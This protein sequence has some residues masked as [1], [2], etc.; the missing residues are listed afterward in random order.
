MGIH[1][2]V[3]ESGT[4]L[5]VGV[6]GWWTD[7]M[8][9]RLRVHVEATSAEAQRVLAYFALGLLDA[10]AAG[11]LTRADACATFF[12]PVFLELAES[13]LLEP[14]LMQALHA[15]SELEDL[16]RLAPQ[17]LEPTIQTIRGKL[18]AALAHLS[19]DP[20]AVNGKRLVKVESE[21]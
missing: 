2:F 5:D 14:G 6:K 12:I 11:V 16:E 13:D 17:A 8:Q 20:L 3:H 4:M 7:P 19:R 9:P 10:T 21:S 18:V 15:A 1:D